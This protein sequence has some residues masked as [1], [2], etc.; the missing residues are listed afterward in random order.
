MLRIKPLCVVVLGLLGLLTPGVARAQFL[1][2][3]TNDS[4]TI[5]GYTGSGGD[6]VVPSE[7]DGLPVTSIGEYAF[8]SGPRSVLISQSSPFPVLIPQLLGSPAIPPPLSPAPAPIILP[9]PSVPIYRAAIVHAVVPKGI[10]SITIP[11]SVTNIGAFAFS[12]CTNLTSVTMSN[13]LVSIGDGAFYKC[14]RLSQVT[15][16]GSVTAIGNDAFSFCTNLAGIKIP[17]GV[18]SIG[19]FAFFGCSK[20]AI[21]SIGAGL[22]NIGPAAFAQCAKLPAITVDPANATYTS[23]YGVLFDKNL[24]TLEAYPGG[25]AGVYVIPSQVTLIANDAFDFCT[26]LTGV[27]IPDTVTTIA[28]NAFY[29]CDSLTKV[30]IPNSVTSLEVGA[31]SGTINLT[32]VT[33]G[34]G[35]TNVVVA[36]P[37]GGV[38]SGCPRLLS[39][40]V[41]VDNAC[42]R[43]A[44]GVLFNKNKTTLVEY[45]AGKSGKYI[46]PNG[47]TS[48][49]GAA[50]SDCTKL[51]NVTIPNSV[52]SISS[53]AFLGCAGL[54]H[55]T[56][57]N[58]VT[59]VGSAAFNDCTRLASLT[60]GSGVT[61]IAAAGGPYGPFDSIF[62]DCPKLV[63]I[64]VDAQNAYYSSAGGVLFDKNKTALLQYPVGL[65]GK[66]TIPGTVNNVAT[67][68][69]QG[70]TLLSS[71]TI[72]DGVTNLADWAYYGCTKLKSVTIPNS[73]ISVGSETFGECTSLTNI[74]F[75]TGIAFL[76]TD[77]FY[78][79]TNL[80]S[81]YFSGN[82]PEDLF[83]LYFLPF[84]NIDATIY[85]Q[86][87]TSGWNDVFAEVPTVMLNAPNPAGSL[88]VAITPSGAVSLGAQWQ[89][90]G[91]FPQ[92]GGAIVS[93]LSA[94]LHTISF[95]PLSGWTAPSSQIVEVGTGST[96]IVWG[97][98]TFN[99]PPQFLCTT[100]P[101]NTLTIIGY[102][103]QGGDGTIPAVIN[104]LTVSSI[105][106][107]A[108]QQFGWFTNLTI[109]GSVV[110]IGDFAFESC[111]NLTN[112]TIMNGVAGIGDNAFAGCFNLAS[113]T[114]PGSVTNIGNDAFDYCQNLTGLVISNGV[115]SIGDEAFYDD[116]SLKSVTI[117]GSV[118]NIGDSAFNS[119][120]SLASVTISNG[121]TSIGN[122]VFDNCGALTSVSIPASVK[123]IGPNFIFC[124]SLTNIAVDP[125]N[126]DFASAGGILFNKT[127][128]TLLQYPGGDDGAFVIPGTVTSIGAWAFEECTNL[129]AVTIPGSVANIGSDAFND[130]GALTSVAI[131]ASVTSIGDGAFS[132]CGGLTNISVDALNSDY[133]SVAGVLF[134]KGFQ[135]L[136]WYPAGRAGSYVI[137]S[138]VASIASGAFANC[139]GLTGVMIPDSVISIGDDAFFYDSNL[140]NVTMSNG[141]VSIGN[142]AFVSCGMVSIT[143]PNTVTTIGDSAFQDCQYLAS[144]TI[145]SSVT[146]LG[147]NAFANC[148]N[149]TNLIIGGG[150]RSIGNGTFEFCSGLTSVFIPAGVTNLDDDSFGYCSG[151]A[152]IFFE[153][154]APGLNY[155]TFY[156]G[157]PFADDSATVCF[158]P[159]TRGWTNNTFGGLPVVPWPPGTIAPL[160]PRIVSHGIVRVAQKMQFSLMISGAQ[161]AAVVVEA[162]T[163]LYNPV[164]LPVQ[165]NVLVNGTNY[166]SDTESTNYP[167]RFYRV[168]P[169]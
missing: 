49:A 57:P 157:S 140:A 11:G 27:K 9:P 4:I 126:P 98:Y 131:P 149:L 148:V 64:T 10:T 147:G 60:I 48:I 100:N 152:Q 68:A 50:F 124:Y 137:P 102:L 73:V 3:T 82:A 107:N 26:E 38:F 125:L 95:S 77:E 53:N 75:G 90:D 169:Q 65:T 32:T 81:I 87:G 44:N 141:V 165:T 1:F 94:G 129:Y 74:S 160:F 167:S 80:I 61:N 136:L 97:S 84:E 120:R 34:S 110:S 47:V 35:L 154:N 58:G 55:I 159:D 70:C 150:V 59:V 143:I 153:G 135:T 119:C 109:P 101:D 29:D 41:S 36:S 14:S 128:T 118:T 37:L 39:F 155:G 63:N 78:D 28:S 7:V 144:V 117:P 83:A 17:N 92:H 16:P 2:V 6:V 106:D 89:V 156:N 115:D 145:P 122:D 24:D 85:C 88:E 103:G 76:G 99:G 138:G 23:L 62:D 163:N 67:A 151:L 5:T 43:S 51:S 66:Y 123:N 52:A 130:C 40:T 166:F 146:S 108:F 93:G 139:N 46:I 134:D 45:P 168:R 164:W 22:T 20:L 86:A 133:A 33:I 127:L 42:Y 113:V 72:P 15:I 8:N 105:G 54:T 114:I 30:E 79:C 142:N 161:N 158:V 121:V 96:A 132:G 116:F 104:G 18:A 21:A 112:L 31:F 19:S 111:N 13:G 69:F 25:K 56:I 71:V 91:G 12:F 162:C